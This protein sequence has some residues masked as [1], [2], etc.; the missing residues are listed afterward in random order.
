MSSAP[1]QKEAAALDRDDRGQQCREQ[2]G[3]RDDGPVDEPIGRNCRHVRCSV[4]EHRLTAVEFFGRKVLLIR[5]ADPGAFGKSSAGR[6]TPSGRRAYPS[7]TLATDKAAALSYFRGPP[8][9]RPP[10]RRAIQN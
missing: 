9:T 8:S 2:H 10:L 3:A 1:P 5:A 4:V 6:F 7:T